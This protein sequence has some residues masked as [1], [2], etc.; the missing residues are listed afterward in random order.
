[1][2]H[3]PHVHVIFWG[4][5]WIYHTALREKVLDLYRSLNNSS[6]SGILTQYF[7][8]SG[9]IGNETDLSSYTDSRETSVE[10]EGE[11]T[12]VVEGDAEKE[13]HYSINNQPGWGSPGV[14]DQYVV[15]PAPEYEHFFGEFCAYHEWD[16]AYGTT[17]TLL[18][19]PSEEQEE[20]IENYGASYDWQ[21]LQIV[22]AHEWSE[23]ATDPRIGYEGDLGWEGING[24]TYTYK[25]KVYRE[26]EE[27]ADAC[28]GLARLNPAEIASGVW[29]QRIYDN[30]KN[31]I[32]SET[33]A[34]SDPSPARFSPAIAAAS[35]DEASHSAELRSAI[36]SAGYPG[37]Y[38][39]E[40]RRPG[41][42]YTY[43]PSPFGP[44]DED[45]F[46]PVNNSAKVYFLKGET[47]YSAKLSVTS[48]LTTSVWNGS[49]IV[50]SGGETSFTT[51]DWRPQVTI[52]PQTEVKAG[53]AILHGEIDPQGYETEYRFEWGTVA[54]NK[55][56][57]SIPVPDA[58]AGYGTSA[59]PVSQAIEGIKG[60][61]EYQYRIYAHNAEGSHTSS[62]QTFTTP[63]WRPV[64]TVKD[65]GPEEVKAGHAPLKGT[66][67][68]TGFATSYHFEWGTQK[69]FEEGKY[70]HSV[71][72]PDEAVGSGETA[73]AVAQT[74]EG[75]KGESTYHWRLVAENAEGKTASADKALTTPSW[76][77]VFGDSKVADVNRHGATMVAWINPRGFAT[78]YHFEWGTSK[79]YGHVVPVPDEAIGSGE[80]GVEVTRV[81]EGLER[82]TTY[83]FRLVAENSEGSRT[84]LDETFTPAASGFQAESYPLALNGATYTT[85]TLGGS[86]GPSECGETGFVSEI[87]EPVEALSGYS[88]SAKC[89]LF[90][91]SVALKANGCRLEFH[92]GFREGS[93][94]AGE[95]VI[96]PAGCGPITFEGA[97]CKISYPAQS[98]L[99]ASFENSGSGSTAKV[100]VSMNARDVHYVSAGG[101]A[102]PAGT[103]HN[104]TITGT[105]QILGSSGGSISVADAWQIAPAATTNAAG[106]LKTSAATLNGTVNPNFLPTTYQFEYGTTTSYGKTAPASPK[107][108]GS[109]GKSLSVSEAISGL[110]AATTYHYR[111]SASNSEGTT[112]GA[113]QAF[114]TPDLRPGL[115]TEAPTSVKGGAATLRGTVNP[116]GSA[117]TYRFEYGTT[118]SYG[119]TAPAS[120]KSVGSG[121]EPVAV[122]EAL[123]GL[124][125]NTVYHYRLAAENPEGSSYG[126]DQTFEIHLPRY[127][128][129]AYPATLSGEQSAAAKLTFKVQ[130]YTA[131]CTKATASGT[132]SSSSQTLTLSPSYSECT[133]FNFTGATVAP[134]GCTYVLHAGPKWSAAYLGTLDISCS[135]GKSIEITV[136]NCAV[137]IGSQ[138]GLKVL[139]STVS[140]ESP[141]ALVASLN[142][143][144]LKYTVTKAGVTCPLE[145]K[146]NTN[147]TFTGTVTVHAESEAKAPIA[148]IASGEDEEA[149]SPTFEAE[150][151]AATLAGEQEASAKQTFTIY[152]SSASCNKATA[153]GT[154]SS[155]S[156][157]LTLSPSYSECTAFGFTGATVAPNGCT[158]ATQLGE[159]IA[160]GKYSGTF[161]I[162][163]SEGKAIEIH[164]G[165]CTAKVGAQ[166]GLAK[167]EIE[168]VVKSGKDAISLIANV[169][170]LKYTVTEASYLCPLE[171]GT[172][173][174]GKFAGTT[175]VQ[176]KEAGG[177]LQGLRAS[178]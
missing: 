93:S 64:V 114:T 22:A 124:S 80:E 15:I 141:Q 20:C 11:T 74:M 78:H 7:D 73:V 169:S 100:L 177:V 161:A 25:G 153:S 24:E 51:P 166:S 8:H 150:E 42:Q 3:R 1:V 125:A 176:G 54:G 98:G 45:S 41:N 66:V 139:R 99:A 36:N 49:S 147:G 70:G 146:T 159:A 86:F 97:G 157:T 131:S 119:K 63:D 171:L 27:I 133:A 175:T 33:C 60:S 4:H 9:P 37:G 113:D 174:N 165:L 52:K 130:G 121:K 101:P 152:G 35:V 126:K 151:Y 21:E 81:L 129:G 96:A 162:S 57:H 75:L 149:H 30:Y 67:N 135:T 158:Y 12:I 18:P 117:T 46:S 108:A 95:A 23:T 72:V 90:G 44:I 83:H 17:W 26:E 61:T 65:P 79:S 120:P 137:S 164:G 128:A 34:G 109:G 89:A 142:A 32:W 163:C 56:D 178:G 145:E 112:H 144:G 173:S 87:S 111:I 172:Y 13:V 92:P 19:Y 118:T 88:L 160:A 69:E 68:P 55:F 110:E 77:P 132:L 168:D 148:L 91:I 31:S 103:Y 102:C 16:H 10:K 143:K 122:S 115:T 170:S 47:T 105:W 14:E 138:S 134:N 85:L 58:G 94:F 39:F 38:Q 82:N 155:A 6:Y 84:S 40:F 76:R 106:S 116:N 29:A 107:S 2:Q 104:G 123:S 28:Y 62:V 43:V 167:I 127:E 140:S 50:W 59:V 53:K 156:Q 48:Q 136:G 154:L 71:P 5:G